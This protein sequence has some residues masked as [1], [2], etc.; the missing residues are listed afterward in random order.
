MVGLAGEG[1]SFDGNGMY[2]RFQPGGGDDTLKMGP[3]SNPLYGNAIV[4]PIGTR[5]AYTG[6]RPPYKSDVPCYQSTPPD[7]NGAATGPPDGNGQ[8]ATRSAR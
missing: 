6:Q 1:A 8:P 3:A 4:P 2:V 7:L 5:P